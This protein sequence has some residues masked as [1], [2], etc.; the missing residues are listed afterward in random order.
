MT[1]PS[2]KISKLLLEQE[3][4]IHSISNVVPRLSTRRTF[5]F[6][7]ILYKMPQEQPHSP[8]DN[9]QQ[10][11]QSSRL[12]KPQLILPTFSGNW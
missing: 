3:N 12:L 5:L 6:Y 10:Q 7:F 1:V 11:Q 8:R 4:I 2:K 9:N